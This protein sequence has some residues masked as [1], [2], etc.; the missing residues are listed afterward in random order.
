VYNFDRPME[1]K[2]ES[3]APNQLLF[4]LLRHTL[5]HCRWS[6]PYHFSETECWSKRD[7]QNKIIPHPSQSVGF[8]D[9]S[10]GLKWRFTLTASGEGHYIGATIPVPAVCLHIHRHETKELTCC[11]PFFTRCTRPCAIPKLFGGGNN[12]ESPGWPIPH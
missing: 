7:A 10:C 9:S 12:F 11:I 6:G 5:Q 1:L 8:T 3:S 4:R 2:L